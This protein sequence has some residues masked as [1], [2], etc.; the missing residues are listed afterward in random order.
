MDLYV[1]HRLLTQDDI[2]TCYSNLLAVYP[3]EVRA[4]DRELDFSQLVRLLDP[5]QAIIAASHAQAD[6]R[7]TRI[8]LAQIR[9]RVTVHG[10]EVS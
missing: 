8:V 5:G 4:G 10:G 7:V 2:D 9:P 1:I 6:D 3:G